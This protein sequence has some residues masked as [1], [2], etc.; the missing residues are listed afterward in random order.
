MVM[1]VEVAVG[2]TVEEGQ[3]L[4]V[5]EAMKMNTYVRAPHAGRVV[6]VLAQKGVSVLAGDTLLRIA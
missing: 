4:V 1:S 3:Q 5:L 6:M 2:D